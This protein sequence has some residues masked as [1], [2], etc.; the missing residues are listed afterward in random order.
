MNL[1]QEEETAIREEIDSVKRKTEQIF[2][3]I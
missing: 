3:T 1:V 2:E